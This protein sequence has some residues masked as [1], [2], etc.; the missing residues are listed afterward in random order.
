MVHVVGGDEMLRQRRTEDLLVSLALVRF[1]KRPAL[2]ELPR[3]LQ[4]DIRAFFGIYTRALPPGGY[5]ALPLAQVKKAGR[6]SWP[7]KAGSPKGKVWMA[8]DFDAPLEDFR[9]YME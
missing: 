2:S 5:V 8:P 3:T 6:T 9:E 4:R 7:C 1:R